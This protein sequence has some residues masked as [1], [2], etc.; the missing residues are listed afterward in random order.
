V[1]RRPARNP[2]GGPGRSWRSRHLPGVVRQGA[3]TLFLA[4]CGTLRGQDEQDEKAQGA[5]SPTTRDYWY[6]WFSSSRLLGKFFYLLAVYRHLR[7]EPVAQGRAH[8]PEVLDDEISSHG[9]PLELLAAADARELVLVTAH[10]EKAPELSAVRLEDNRLETF[11]L[12][13]LLQPGIVFESFA[14]CLDGLSLTASYRSPETDEEPGIRHDPPLC[15]S[16]GHH[17]ACGAAA[18]MTSPHVLA[19]VH[20]AA[21]GNGPHRLAPRCLAP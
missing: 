21:R 4:V 10:Q 7:H 19:L 15:L 12:T 18:C 6:A 13:F 2:L 11:D 17:Q 20:L 14:E 3:G 1:V 16:C 9:L 8:D 5:P